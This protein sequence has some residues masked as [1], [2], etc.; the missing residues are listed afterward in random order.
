MVKK[1]TPTLYA[2]KSRKVSGKR[3]ARISRCGWRLFYCSVG[4]SATKFWVPKL[5]VFTSSLCTYAGSKRFEK[6]SKMTHEHSWLWVLLTNGFEIISGNIP[7]RMT[8]EAVFNRVFLAAFASPH[9][10]LASVA[11]NTSQAVYKGLDNTH[12]ASILYI[13][14]PPQYCMCKFFWK[15]APV[16]IY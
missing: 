16:R 10:T 8:L 1:S 4:Q 14:K 6:T 5:P 9:T 7:S 13:Q 11:F 3:H 12:I 15:F 2:R